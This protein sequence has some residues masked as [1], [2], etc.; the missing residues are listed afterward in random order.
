MQTHDQLVIGG[1]DW[2][3]PSRIFRS[4]V[5]SRCRRMRAIAR[6][7]SGQTVIAGAALLLAIVGGALWTPRPAWAVACGETIT[8][9]VKL[10]QDL[11]DCPGTGL[12]IGAD[13]VTV[14]LNGHTLDGDNGPDNAIVTL[15][16][17][18]GLTI[19]GPGV[20]T[21]FEDGI[22]V[23]GAKLKVLG[24]TF[25]ALSGTAINIGPC[26]G[27]LIASN[28]MSEV[29]SAMDLG[30]GSGKLT[31]RD[32][33]INGA[34]GFG[35]VVADAVGASV[36]GN[37]VSDV[38]FEGIILGASG[39]TVA[40]NRVMRTAGHG[41]LVAGATGSKVVGNTVSST[42]GSGIALS[43]ASANR[44]EGNVVSGASGG[45]IRLLDALSDGNL[46]RRN[47][48]FGNLGNGILVPAGAG[49][50]V[51]EG[52]AADGN[53]FDGLR[54]EQAGTVVRKTRAD[55]NGGL[56]IAAV[57]GTVDGG[58]NR[59]RGNLVAAQCEGLACP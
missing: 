3:A 47:A 59:A 46:L 48:T 17:R 14:D 52:N 37:L 15:A 45:G 34:S 16:D 41:I 54:I 24:V 7:N 50:T 30:G 22:L 55:G 12:V 51:L 20:I 57:A 56:G 5:A 27:S 9:S 43:E 2:V 1:G 4:G 23:G 58:G 21:G 8:A 13:N 38:A 32:N 42:A 19:K 33:V 11:L 31:V 35:I 26:P 49:V 10:D 39:N 44:I 29:G 36:V 25:R 6:W 53:Q 28:T 40:K 18:A